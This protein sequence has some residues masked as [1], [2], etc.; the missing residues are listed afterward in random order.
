MAVVTK[1]Y[2]FTEVFSRK[3]IF[4][5]KSRS[6]LDTVGM[7]LKLKFWVQNAAHFDLMLIDYDLALR[8]I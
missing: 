4:F 6:K 3:M 2:A 7:F 5:F 8:P 1:S